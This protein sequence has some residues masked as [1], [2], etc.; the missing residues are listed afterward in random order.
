M[1]YGVIDCFE[2][3]IYV[4]IGF[5]D[6]GDFVLGLVVEVGGGFLLFV[7]FGYC[8]YFYFGLL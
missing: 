1:S 6:R 8:F 4:V 2:G 5:V 3:Y 7:F